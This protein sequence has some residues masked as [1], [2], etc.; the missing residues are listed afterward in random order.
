MV[1]VDGVTAGAAGRCPHLHLV[2]SCLKNRT[3]NPCTICLH[4]SRPTQSLTNDMD[5]TWRSLQAVARTVL[6]PRSIQR[7]RVLVPAVNEGV[8]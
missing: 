1:L 4:S 5:A 6:G 2:A 3:S 7:C 8:R